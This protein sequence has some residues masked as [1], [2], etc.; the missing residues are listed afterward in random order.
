MR[1][2]QWQTSRGGRKSSCTRCFC[3]SLEAALRTWLLLSE[4][5][6]SGGF[7]QWG[8]GTGPFRCHIEKIPKEGREGRRGAA[9]S[10]GT[11]VRDHVGS[12]LGVA[13]GEL[14]SGH[15][16]DFSGFPEAPDE[17]M[18]EKGAKNDPRFLAPSA[19]MGRLLS[20]FCTENKEFGVWKC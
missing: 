14:R 15:M 5:E 16:H 19:E 4:L 12:G 11:Q 9:A 6:T 18:R 3:G 1:L 8:A 2:E 13:A 7:A 20:S 10:A 17:R